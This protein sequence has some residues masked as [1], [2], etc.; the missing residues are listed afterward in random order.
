[1]PLIDTDVAVDIL[2][3][4]P[5]ALQWLNGLGSAGCDA[6]GYTAMELYAGCH[7]AAEQR[8][9][10]AVVNS[11]VLVWPSAAA[12]DAALRVYRALHLSHGIGFVDALIAQTA[13]EQNEPLHTFN[14]KHFQHVPGLRVVQPYTKKNP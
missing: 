14:V 5:P 7:N 12:R 10:D 1:M 13:I 6:S 9:A 8:L 4:F 2:R 11:L 3:R